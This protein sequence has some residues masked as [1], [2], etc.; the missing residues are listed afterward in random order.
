MIQNRLCP[1]RWFWHM[2]GP[3]GIYSEGLG[4]GNCRKTE[5][6][7]VFGAE[8]RNISSLE[9]EQRPEGSL[10]APGVVA[11]LSAPGLNSEKG[12]RSRSAAALIA[13][14]SAV[15]HQERRRA[16]GTICHTAAASR[17]EPP[18]SR[19]APGKPSESVRGV[20]LPCW[21]LLIQSHQ[22]QTLPFLLKI[23]KYF[24]P[25]GSSK[26]QSAWVVCLEYFKFCLGV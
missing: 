6:A 22:L 19:S 5:A 18:L 1:F 13:R 15:T 8:L 26:I 23:K 7:S 20:R 3:V 10:L 25:V 17:S 4:G 2:T 11:L 14:P 16:C 12:A 9:E 24:S 21:K